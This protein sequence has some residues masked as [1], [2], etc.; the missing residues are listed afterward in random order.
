MSP[1]SKQVH[2]SGLT[3]VAN[4]L[5]LLDATGIVVRDLNAQDV[6]FLWI[7]IDSE[8]RRVDVYRS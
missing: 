7:D 2:L 5:T 4:S 3:G 1:A 8:V 6:E